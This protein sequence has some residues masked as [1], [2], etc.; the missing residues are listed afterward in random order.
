MLI[1]V[2]KGAEGCFW[3]VRDTEPGDLLDPKPS[4]AYRYDPDFWAASN[5]MTMGMLRR[6]LDR[7]PDDAILHC[8]GTNEIYLHYCPG[9]DA[10]SEY[11]ARSPDI[12]R[13]DG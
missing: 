9:T 8:C 6:Y 10:L 12:L 11:E 13:D 4:G 1:P 2:E 5:H 3:T 7:I